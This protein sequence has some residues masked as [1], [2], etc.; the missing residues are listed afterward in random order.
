M[1]WGSIVVERLDEK[2][3]VIPN[4]E[5]SYRDAKLWPGGSRAWDWNET[6]TGHFQGIQIADVEEL[7]TYNPETV[8]LSQGVLHAL[9]VPQS[10][11]D[12]I[13][14]QRPNVEVIVCT[15]KKAL[16]TYN[17]LASKGVRVSALIHTT[18][19]APQN[20]VNLYFSWL[21]LAS[22]CVVTCTKLI[23]PVLSTR[24]LLFLQGYHL[25]HIGYWNETF[26]FL[27]YCT[28]NVKTC[29]MTRYTERLI[30]CWGWP[31]QPW[32]CL[33]V[34]FPPEQARTAWLKVKHNTTVYCRLDA[35]V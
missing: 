18:C 15:S 25:A 13:K 28:E 9:Q 33:T 23:S 24:F 8:I 30:V 7:L 21:T 6:G 32:K 4:S 5:V 20:Y 14:K 22:N 34:H 2:G 27:A 12:Y 17:D 3:V 1:R 10:T 29:P 26:C 11:V 31:V 16:E 19:W 35:W